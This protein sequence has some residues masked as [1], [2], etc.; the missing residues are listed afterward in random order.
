M[1]KTIA[2]LLL[3]SSNSFAEAKVMA[4]PQDEYKTACFQSYTNADGSMSASDCDSSRNNKTD[5]LKIAENGCAQG[6]VAIRI[7][8]SEVISSCFPSGVVQL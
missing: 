3:V 2:A 7:R 4:Q 1:K 8:K 5:K 6:Q